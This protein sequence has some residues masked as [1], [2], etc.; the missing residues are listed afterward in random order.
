MVI[1]CCCCSPGWGLEREGGVWQLGGQGV[2]A[3]APSAGQSTSQPPL[4]AEGRG[5]GWSFRPHAVLQDERDRGVFIGAGKCF[6]ATAV[7]NVHVDEEWD[8]LISH[9]R[10]RTSRCRGPGND[11][12]GTS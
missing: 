5:A 11:P 9:A 12:G 10:H 7:E 2:Q 1:G 8:L 3:D 6:A 4:I